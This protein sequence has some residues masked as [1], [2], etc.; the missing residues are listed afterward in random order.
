MKNVVFIISSGSEKEQFSMI[1][2]EKFKCFNADPEKL[3]EDIAEKVAPVLYQD[4][5]LNASTFEI[6]GRHLE[7][8]AME[9]DIGE[10]PQLLFKQ[11]YSRVVRSKDELQEILKSA[12]SEQ[13]GSELVGIQA[14][15]TVADQAIADSYSSTLVPI[16]LST[17]DSGL[18]SHLVRDL[19]RLSKHVN[20]VV[21]GKSTKT[22][23]STAGALILKKVD[24]EAVRDTL[25]EISRLAKA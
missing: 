20:V 4:K 24:E 6:I 25:T 14:V 16:I 22:I 19:K 12:L 3:F 18:I 9:L 17:D 2:S 23:K 7:D 5:E 1:A 11:Q 10:Y 21:S 15:R 13:V 8:K